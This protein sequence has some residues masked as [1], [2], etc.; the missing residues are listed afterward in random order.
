MVVTLEFLLATGINFLITFKV[1]NFFR[2]SG[3]AGSDPEGGGL[4]HL[5]FLGKILG[6]LD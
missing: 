1:V 2:G 3:S 5:P 6:Q 4:C